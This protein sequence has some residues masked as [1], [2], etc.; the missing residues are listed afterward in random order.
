M[1]ELAIPILIVG[2]TLALAWP[3]G[4]FCAWMAVPLLVRASRVRSGPPPAA[5]KDKKLPPAA[6]R[7]A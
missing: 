1:L 6:E 7:K 4:L 5:E 2:L 3:L